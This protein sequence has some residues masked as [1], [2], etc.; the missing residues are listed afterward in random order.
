MGVLFKILCIS[1]L[2]F[3]AKDLEFDQL[4]FLVILIL[5]YAKI[6]LTPQKNKLLL[7]VNS[8]LGKLYHKKCIASYN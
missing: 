8:F 1:H 3:K 6:F 4:G 7:S 5:K 2:V